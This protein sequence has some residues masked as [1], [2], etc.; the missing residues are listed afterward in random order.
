MLRQGINPSWEWK[1]EGFS[2]PKD[3]CLS[4]KLSDMTIG[5]V[6]TT[7]DG[8]HDGNKETKNKQFKMIEQ[9]HAHPLIYVKALDK[10]LP[11]KGKFERLS[12]LKDMVHTENKGV[13]SRTRSYSK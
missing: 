5:M 7:M 4:D 6:Q 12:I 13:A 3:V 10:S 1:F 11:K 2:F 9:Q 8:N